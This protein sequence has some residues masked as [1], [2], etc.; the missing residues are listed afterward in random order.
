[1]TREPVPLPE[2]KTTPILEV[3]AKTTPPATHMPVMGYPLVIPMAALDEHQA[4]LNH[5]QTLDTLARRGG[6]SL[7]EA[8]ALI[9]RKP[10]HPMSDAYAM[11]CLR[12]L[13]L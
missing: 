10:F 5:G 13:H 7:S 6:I 9:E 4:H 8:V 3:E 1:M 12:G 2:C 11:S